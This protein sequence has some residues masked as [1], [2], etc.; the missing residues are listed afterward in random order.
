MTAKRGDGIVV[1]SE[2]V[3]QQARRGEI[4]KVIESPLG[5]SYEVRWEDGH[6][7]TF[8]PAGGSARIVEKP[9]H[10]TR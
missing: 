10:T 1:E 7:S 3:G 8:Q 6:E 5:V 4:L 2:R 9:V